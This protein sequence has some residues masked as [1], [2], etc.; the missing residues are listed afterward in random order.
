MRRAWAIT[1]ALSVTETVS[2][3]ILYYA[4]AAFLVPMQRDLGF[5]AAQLTGAFSL[6]LLVAAAVGILIGRHLDRHAPRSLMTGGSIAGVLR[7][8]LASRGPDHGGVIAELAASRPA[9]RTRAWAI[10]GALSVTETVAWG[11]LYY[12][13]AVFLIPMHAEL[14]FSTAELTGAFRRRC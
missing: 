5:S 8:R 11:I 6:S 13:Y 3:G 4:F 7:H 14:G 1:G 9:L 10:V 12:A 2:Y